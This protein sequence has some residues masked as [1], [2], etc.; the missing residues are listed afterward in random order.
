MEFCLQVLV[1]AIEAVCLNYEARK[2]MQPNTH[3]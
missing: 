2:K 1:S 3:C